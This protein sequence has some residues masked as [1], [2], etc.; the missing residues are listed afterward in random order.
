MVVLGTGPVV[1]PVFASGV[2]AARRWPVRLNYVRGESGIE[3]P[4]TR[5]LQTQD[6]PSTLTATTGHPRAD[7]GYQLPSAVSA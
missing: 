7:V 4:S 6:R 2:N 1:Q 5:V 3:V